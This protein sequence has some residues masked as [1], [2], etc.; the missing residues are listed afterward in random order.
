MVWFE[1]RRERP[2]QEAASNYYSG[3]QAEPPPYQQAADAAGNSFRFSPAA[4]A[5]Y[6]SHTMALRFQRQ[7]PPETHPRF[8]SAADRERCLSQ[9]LPAARL[10]Y[11]PRY[12]QSTRG[13][14][15]MW[16]YGHQPNENVV[17]LTPTTAQ[18][19]YAMDSSVQTD[20]PLPC[21]LDHSPFAVDRFVVTVI[22]KAPAT[23][24]A[25]GLASKPYPPFRLPGWNLESVGY[26]SDDGHKYHNDPMG[27]RTY[28]PTFGRSGDAI[29]VEYT[30][31]SGQ[32]VY[33]L[34]GRSL[35]PAFFNVRGPLYPTIGADG[36][37]Q[38]QVQYLP[39]QPTDPGP[40]AG[41]PA[42]QFS[43][44]PPSPQASE[45]PPPYSAL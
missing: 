16:D 2:S 20:L 38:L 32:V 1:K 12:S 11:P 18:F 14:E 44:R 28:G 39:S 45:P 13:A 7:F 35:G 5:S 40:K 36:P 19:R 9:G 42:Y 17:F 3:S 33:S 22:G 10:V 37:C 30:T 15:A 27:G 26:H 29:E 4:N 6:D 41:A 25:V 24:V 8:L 31:A 21:T 34:N 43:D 23:V